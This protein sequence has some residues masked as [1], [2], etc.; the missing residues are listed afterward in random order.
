VNGLQPPVT[1]QEACKLKKRAPL[2][3]RGEGARFF[4]CFGE[5]QKK[6]RPQAVAA[7]GLKIACEKDRPDFS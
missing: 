5:E 2:A 7:P 1:E 3:E 6:A 4:F